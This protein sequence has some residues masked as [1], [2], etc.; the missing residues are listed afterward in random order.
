[1]AESQRKHGGASGAGNFAS[2]H[3]FVLK[4]T[5]Q[6]RRQYGCHSVQYTIE[7]SNGQVRLKARAKT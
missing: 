1:M 6:I 3:N 2:F 4:K 7:V 5:E